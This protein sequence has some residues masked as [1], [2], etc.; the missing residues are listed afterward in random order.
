MGNDRPVSI[1]SEEWSVPGSSMPPFRKI[2]D[3]RSGDE[4][5]ASYDIVRG[6]PD[7]GLFQIPPDF[8]IVDESGPFAVTYIFSFAQK[9]IR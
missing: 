3:P 2:S 7:P 6:E 4:T 9:A 5:A 1:V 8:Q